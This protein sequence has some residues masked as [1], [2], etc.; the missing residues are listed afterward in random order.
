MVLVILI[1]PHIKLKSTMK[2]QKKLNKLKKISGEKLR[3]LLINII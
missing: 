1:L 2:R 3:K